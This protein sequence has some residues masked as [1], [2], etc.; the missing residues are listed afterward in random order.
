[1]SKLVGRKV[2]ARL[3]NVKNV[4]SYSSVR[5]Y[6]LLVCRGTTVP[7]TL[8]TII[9]GENLRLLIFFFV[10][11]TWS[12]QYPNSSRNLRPFLTTYKKTSSGLLLA[13]VHH[14]LSG[15]AHPLT[16]RKAW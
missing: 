9:C 15:S 4:L 10:W 6:S 2:I 3:Q 8:M 7:V 5:P 13:A 12:I 1:M 16:S 11:L 14:L